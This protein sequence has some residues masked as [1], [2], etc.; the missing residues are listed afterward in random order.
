M[1]K[2]GETETWTHVK[3]EKACNIINLVH[4]KMDIEQN[5]TDQATRQVTDTDCCG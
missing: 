1:N 5:L 4:H 2:G 3:T